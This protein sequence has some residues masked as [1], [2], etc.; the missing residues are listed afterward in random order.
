MVNE[1]ASRLTHLL[2][3]RFKVLHSVAA[4]SALIGVSNF[5]GLVVPA[6]ITLLGAGSGAALATV[7]GV[8]VDVPAMLAV[9]NACNNRTRRRFRGAPW[10]IGRTVVS[11]RGA[12]FDPRLRSGSARKPF[13]ACGLLSGRGDPLGEA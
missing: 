10:A 5:F 2:R 8:L 9:C 1:Y 7:I 12:V 4:P 13:V 6:A 3:R 11:R